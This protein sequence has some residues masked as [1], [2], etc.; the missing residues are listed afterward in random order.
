MVDFKNFV[1]RK[2]VISK[3][4]SKKVVTCD[5]NPNFTQEL[6]SHYLEGIGDAQTIVDNAE[7]CSKEVCKYLEGMATSIENEAYNRGCDVGE[8]SDIQIAI[9]IINSRIEEISKGVKELVKQEV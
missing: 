4:L 5:S 8:G 1:N 7:S 6:D 2:E 9:D 3:L